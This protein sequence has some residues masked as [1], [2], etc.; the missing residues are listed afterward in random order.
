MNVSRTLHFSS[1][2][3]AWAV[4]DD[5][6]NQIEF[7]KKLQ[8]SQKLMCFYNE[9]VRLSQRRSGEVKSYHQDI[10]KPYCLAE[11]SQVWAKAAG[12]R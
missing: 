7:L 8:D 6:L 4:R 3:M 5:P 12:T 10:G 1:H 11:N 2:S 9:A